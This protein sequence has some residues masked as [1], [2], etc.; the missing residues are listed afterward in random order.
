MRRVFI[1][2]FVLIQ[3]PVLFCQD[4][5]PLDKGIE[6]FFPSA[7]VNR[8]YVDSLTN[9]LFATGSF[10]QDG[11]CVSMTGVA[12]WN[13]SAW[14]STRNFYSASNYKFALTKFD[15]TLILNGSF[16]PPAST[17]HLAKWNGLTWDTLAN[18][19]NYFVS[20]FAEKNG[21][22][23]MA[24][25]FDRI[26]GDSTF[27]LGKFDGQS[28]SGLTPFEGDNSSLG[29]VATCMAFY[30]DTLYVGGDFTTTTNGPS[31]DF[32]RYVNGILD[33]VDPEFIGTGATS[34]IETMIVFRDEL[35]IGGY[36]RKQDGFTGDYIMKWNGTQFLEVG[37]GV[38]NRVTSLAVHNDRLYVGG[39][40]T[41]AGDSS[42]TYLAIWDGMVW[43]TFNDTF[44][45]GTIIRDIDFYNDSLVISG[46]FKTIN[47]DTVNHIAKYNHSLPTGIHSYSQSSAVVDVFPNPASDMITFQ[48]SGEQRSRELVIYD[49]LGKEVWREE[50]S[51]SSLIIS[52]QKFPK[53]IYFYS[54]VEKNG[55][56]VQ[57]K[58]LVQ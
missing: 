9:T 37:G 2:L 34:Y 24:G 33:T 18:S 17:R 19:P 29:Y 31:A 25:A 11:N 36:F 43:Q 49:A 21:E 44:P 14:D 58:F 26:G 16:Y 10:S 6:C 27:L 40:F 45:P 13:G 48:F 15:D 1:L 23:Y 51:E 39:Y 8:L 5:L 52:V 28:L 20:C 53:G 55:T 57:G 56:N 50:T 41:Q 4:W 30:R 42:T 32:A 54:V 22:L 35:Y 47:G 7:D 3:Q 46:H 12:K 38:N